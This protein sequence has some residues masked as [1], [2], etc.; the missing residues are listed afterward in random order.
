MRFGDLIDHAGI[1]AQRLADIAQHAARPVADDDGGQGG[2][3]PTVFIVDVLD[4]F[5]APLVLEIDVDVGWLV[6]F[7]RNEALE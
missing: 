6:A 7:F 4:H 2:A 1:D 3:Q 5:F